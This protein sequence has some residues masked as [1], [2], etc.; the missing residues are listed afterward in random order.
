MAVGNM[1]N[2]EPAKL[3]RQRYLSISRDSAEWIG[4]G[5][6]LVNKPVAETLIDSIS[7]VTDVPAAYCERITSRIGFRLK[8]GLRDPMQNITLIFRFSSR[9]FRCF[10]SLLGGRTAVYHVG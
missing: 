5:D 2:D 1:P 6:Q 9:S 4:N 8:K 7:S 3:T 10:E